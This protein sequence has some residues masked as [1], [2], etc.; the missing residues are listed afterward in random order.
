[1]INIEQAQGILRQRYPDLEAVGEG[2][3]RG[4]DKY[5]ERE[6]AVRYFDLND[7]LANTSK[8]IKRYQEQILSDAYFS[9]QTPTDLRW[10]HYLYFI[11]SAEH[12]NDSDF[13]Q[14]RAVVE[15]DREY[16]RK[17]VVFENDLA[18]TIAPR[19]PART[20]SE[21]PPDLASTWTKRLDDNGLGYVLDDQ[22]TVPEVVR[23]IAAG[24]REGV[25]RIASPMALLPSET[26][27][28]QHFLKHLTIHG[29]RPHPTNKSHSLGRVNLIVGSNGV[30][31]TSL[32][33]AIEFVYC[34]RTRRAGVVP[35][36][37]TVTADLQGTPE[38]LTSSTSPT[39]L[40][41]RHSSWYAK[42]ELRTVTIEDSFGK[43]NFLDTDAA[44][45]L[46]VATSSDQ[47]GA[48]VA[49]LVLGAEA[50]K[51]ADRLRRVA[52]R[53]HEDL[54]EL[55]R[56]AQ[57][58]ETR[59]IAIH[60]RLEALKSAPKVSDSLLAELSTAL[61]QVGWLQLPSGKPEVEQLRRQLSVVASSV[62]LL[63]NSKFDVLQ[64]DD[65]GLQRFWSELESA[66]QQATE[67]DDRQKSAVLESADH[68]RKQDEAASTIAAIERLLP[69]VQAGFNDLVVKLQALR[70]AVNQ[71]TAVLSALNLPREPREFFTSYLDRPVGEVATQAIRLVSDLRS[72]VD[73]ARQALS[74]FESTQSH[75][76]LVRERLL[77]AAKELLQKGADPDH[78]PVCHTAF[79]EGQLL[80][81]MLMNADDD[82]SV[83]LST[84]RED[85]EQASVRLRATEHVEPALRTLAAFA[86]GDAISMRVDEALDRVETMQEDL[87][88]DNAELS[89]I[90][91][92]LAALAA[93]GLTVQ[94][95]PTLLSAA[96]YADM[97]SESEILSD[98]ETAT[99]AI[100]STRSLAEA[101]VEKLT[102]IRREAES[103]AA[104]LSLNV[105]ASTSELAD[106]V[107]ARRTSFEA[108]M[109]ARQS[110][111]HVLKLASGSSIET[112]A[113]GLASCQELLVKLV[114]ADAQERAND[115]GL[116]KEAA[117]LESLKT[118]ADDYK[119][120]I[121]RLAG[122]EVILV[123]LAEQSS[124]A[125]LAAQILSENASEIARTFASIHLPNEFDLDVHDGRLRIM[126][127]Q[128]QAA[129]EL[130]QMSTGQRAAFALSL[131]LAMNARLRTGPP[132]LLFDDP[133]AHVDDI[134]VLSFLDHLRALALD[135][136][137]QIFFATADTK[138]AGLFRQKFRFLGTEN[139]REIQLNRD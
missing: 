106:E 3:F 101:S 119:T 79:E 95:L 130:S 52:D 21:L 128:T 22:V 39:R 65:Q 113:A 114:T 23:R 96:G 80:T 43:F 100:A 83:R 68:A 126:R 29:F 67:L 48:D 62:G 98:I 34:G 84:L 115:A 60:H 12:A 121:E 9:T 107:L 42:T 28:A 138:L 40:R 78:C 55:R 35:T 11:T 120:K 82:S 64:S 7:D 5:A 86:G 25:D 122:A 30:G 51:L 125:E 70:R 102:Q 111:L 57:D 2:I 97:P 54:K 90:E 76:T 44:V 109:E 110:L 31:K 99:G 81:R 53:L 103:L 72:R 75:L 8:A 61:E 27:A 118:R 112:L 139:F 88:R 19:A 46:S 89:S 58:N 59:R 1:M 41:A 116:A 71:R 63:R 135:G 14:S 124:G 136:T 36:N 33:E 133:V 6:Y 16:A 117:A 49:R 66:L 129:V 77:S 56:D 4:V 123:G 10:N 92:S 74:S 37:T 87:A 26:A 104:Q 131:F 105:A 15:A 38:K 13:K 108:A 137:R 73:Q 93:N 47:V 50:E 18:R 45:K 17:Q 20:T 91:R 69:Y 127:R 134:N 132:V 32:L 24:L 94:A 85:V